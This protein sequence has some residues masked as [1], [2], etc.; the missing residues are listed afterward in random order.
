MHC[1]DHR[2]FVFINLV[3]VLQVAGHLCGNHRAF[4]RE[5]VFGR[6]LCAVMKIAADGQLGF[7]L[8]CMPGFIERSL[9]A[10]TAK[11]A[12]KRIT[13]CKE[14]RGS[15][16]MSYVYDDRGT[17]E[18]PSWWNRDAAKADEQQRRKT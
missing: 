1:R 7:K 16:A 10:M 12:G 8:Q 17:D 9:L 3:I 14:V 4:K 18:P 6:R 13:Y 5:Q 15:H 11:K 2:G